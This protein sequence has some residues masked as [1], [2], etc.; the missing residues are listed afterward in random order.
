MPD[1][2]GHAEVPSAGEL[3]DQRVEHLGHWPHHDLDNQ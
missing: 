2:R 3:D 1:L